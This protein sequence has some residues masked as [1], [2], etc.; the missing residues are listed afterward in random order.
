MDE[1]T[2][3]AKFLWLIVSLVTVIFLLMY[4]SLPP[5]AADDYPISTHGRYRHR[6]T[7]VPKGTPIDQRPMLAAIYCLIAIP[8]AVWAGVLTSREKSNDE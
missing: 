8:L 7:D 5:V 1:E 2:P 6:Y 3:R 4:V